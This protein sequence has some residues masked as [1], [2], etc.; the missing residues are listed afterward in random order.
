M[1]S[2]CPQILGCTV[3]YDIRLPLIWDFW[4]R[5]ETKVL[6]TTVITFL[7][8][9]MSVQALMSTMLSMGL[10]GVSIQS[11]RVLS[12]SL[13]AMFCWVLHIN[14]MKDDAELGINP[15]H[16][17]IRTTVKIIGRYYFITGIEQF[18]YGILGCSPIQTNGVHTI[19][20]CSQVFSSTSLVG[21]WVAYSK[22]L[23]GPNPPARRWRFGKIIMVWYR[24]GWMPACITLVPNFHFGIVG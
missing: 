21:F 2:E 16:L 23:N 6:S 1:T 13:S 19:F 5:M 10:V 3:Q 11:M 12:L 14:K 15:N 8:F 18:E 24:S 4:S 7:P 9:T 17:A 22:P 20:K